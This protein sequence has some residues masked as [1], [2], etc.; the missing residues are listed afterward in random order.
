MGAGEIMRFDGGVRH[1]DGLLRQSSDKQHF[2]KHFPSVR[3]V[4]HLEFSTPLNETPHIITPK[5][6]FAYICTRS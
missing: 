1:V 5:V 4:C 6:Y 2:A 3:I